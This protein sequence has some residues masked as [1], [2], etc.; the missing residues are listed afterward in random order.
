MRCLECA[1]ESEPREAIAV[2]QDCG[3]GTCLEHARV[4]YGRPSGTIG[5]AMVSERR[6]RCTVCAPDRTGTSRS[7]REHRHHA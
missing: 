1:L 4:T 2:C 7:R 3:A 5:R 6:I